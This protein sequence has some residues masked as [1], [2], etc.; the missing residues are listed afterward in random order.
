MVA[1]TVE[2]VTITAAYTSDRDGWI[3][4]VSRLAGRAPTKLD[5][6]GRHDGPVQGPLD[7]R[8]PRALV[9]SP[10]GSA[11]E[12]AELCGLTART[13]GNRRETLL[14]T[15]AGVVWP[16]IRPTHSGAIFDHLHV[17]S[18]AD[19]VGPCAKR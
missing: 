15:R 8:A 4:A 5:L 3:A 10:R 7:L 14:K 17:T 12:L 11:T 13:V 1:R 6:L 9:E 2:G 18:R 16:L 19:Q